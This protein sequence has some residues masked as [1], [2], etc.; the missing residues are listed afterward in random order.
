MRAK[1]KKAH[2][3]IRVQAVGVAVTLR[4]QRSCLI[5]TPPTPGSTVTLMRKANL[6]LCVNVHLLADMYGDAI[7]RSRRAFK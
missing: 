6:A 1:K 4:P 5:D 2:Y 7:K 3:R